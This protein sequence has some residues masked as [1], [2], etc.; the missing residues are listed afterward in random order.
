MCVG[1]RMRMYHVIS[2]LDLKASNCFHVFTFLN[3]HLIYLKSSFLHFFGS[4][5]IF[6]LENIFLH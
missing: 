6:W 1:V 3:A 5:Y 2:Q 4:N